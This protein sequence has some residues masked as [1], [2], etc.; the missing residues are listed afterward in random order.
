MTR[1]I[2]K[3]CT[4]FMVFFFVMVLAFAEY[5]TNKGIF[6]KK[7]KIFLFSGKNSKFSFTKIMVTVR[8]L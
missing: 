5:N 4:M 6:E 8:I 2:K 3:N 7:D 1:A